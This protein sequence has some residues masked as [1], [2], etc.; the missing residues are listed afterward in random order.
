M[1]IEQAKD[2]AA[3]EFGYDDWEDLLCVNSFTETIEP[4]INMAMEIYAT[5]KI[6]DFKY[7]DGLA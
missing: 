3:Q 5:G 7:Q 6:Y 1:T 4:Y 2:L